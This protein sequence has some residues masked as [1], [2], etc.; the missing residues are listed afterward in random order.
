MRGDGGP[1]L[2]ARFREWESRRSCG[3]CTAC[4][5]IHAVVA[6]PTA[7]Y[8]WCRHC[9]PGVGC[10]VYATRPDECRGY[11]CAWR[12]GFGTDDDR[13]D[14]RGMV[15]DLEVAGERPVIHVWRPLYEQARRLGSAAR[16]ATEIRRTLVDEGCVDVAIAVH[17]V[18]PTP[19]VRWEPKEHADASDE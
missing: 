4:C 9:T 6:V 1:V 14:R 16:M 5:F 13:P 7:A 15:I 17:G 2:D 19:V 18:P 11:H 3:T 12:L 10:G 8:R